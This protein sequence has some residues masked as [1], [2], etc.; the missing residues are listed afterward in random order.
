[1]N[2]GPLKYAEI[3]SSVGAHSLRKLF[4]KKIMPEYKNHYTKQ[5][6]NQPQQFHKAQHWKT[7]EWL[8]FR[9]ILHI[10]LLNVFYKYLYLIFCFSWVLTQKRALSKQWLIASIVIVSLLHSAS[11]VTVSFYLQLMC[12]EMCL[13]PYFILIFSAPWKLFM[14]NLAELFNSFYWQSLM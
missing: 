14:N 10:H 11:E 7:L 13:I 1:M 5:E 2:L 6:Q 8:D 4:K 9:V 3:F 12:Q